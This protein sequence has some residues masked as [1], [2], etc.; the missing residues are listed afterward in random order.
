MTPEL[1]DRSDMDWR[2]S[3]RAHPIH[4]LPPEGDPYVLGRWHKDRATWKGYAFEARVHAKGFLGR[5][6]LK[7]FLMVGRPR[8]GTTLIARLLNQVPHIHCDGEVLHHAVLAPRAFLNRLA[9]IKP[10][11]AYGAKLITYQMFEVQKIADPLSF[12]EQLLADGFT[13]IHLRRGSFAQ[14]LSLSVAQQVQQYHIGTDG[15]APQQQLTLDPQAFVRQV[16]WNTCMLDYEDLLFSRL[17]HVQVDY[18]AHLQ[19]ADQHQA[20]VDRICAAIGV[21][22]GSVKAD[23]QRTGTRTKVEN[24]A[25]LLAALQDAGMQDVEPERAI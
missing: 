2:M 4:S 18:E 21:E 8:S 13:L 3:L 6:Q 17:P 24:K 10:T 11:Q 14:S 16:T 7:K 15:P 1:P 19:D 23:L 9:S 20:T 5:K 12:F 22:S 25:D